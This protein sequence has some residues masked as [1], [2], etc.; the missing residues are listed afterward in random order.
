MLASVNFECIDGFFSCCQ[1][2][3]ELSNDDCSQNYLGI[4]SLDEP[5]RMH[6]IKNL[7]HGTYDLQAPQSLDFWIYHVHRTL[8]T[9]RIEPL[10]RSWSDLDLAIDHR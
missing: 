6:I 5:Y 10:Y 7:I 9:I 8:V 1:L 4:Y 3:R 2:S